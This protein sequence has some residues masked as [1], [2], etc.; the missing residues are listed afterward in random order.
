M[1]GAEVDILA[2]GRMDL[3]DAVLAEMDEVVAAVHY[4]LGMPAAKQTARVLK[5][6]D[7][8]HVRVL[9]HPL[10]RLINERAEFAIDFGKIVAAAAERGVALE[11]DA[12]PDRLDL[13]DVHAR[14]ARAAG[15]KLVT[16]SDA[17]STAGLNNMR[18][19][20]DQAR[21]AW[22]ARGDVLNTLPVGRLLE[23]LKR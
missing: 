15:C 11:I 6:H 19:G 20:V 13:D 18:F 4:R 14:A 22:L 17:H 21:R 9:A 8:R 2:D 5:A 16:S 10:T 3:P 23:A 1:K 7:N 12:H